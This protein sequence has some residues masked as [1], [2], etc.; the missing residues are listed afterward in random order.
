MQLKCAK[1]LVTFYFHTRGNDK[2]Y[3]FLM[4]ILVNFFCLLNEEL[5]KSKNAI[6]G[7][8]VRQINKN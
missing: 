2:I 7:F 1:L 4:T 3:Y 6:N 8:T 5:I